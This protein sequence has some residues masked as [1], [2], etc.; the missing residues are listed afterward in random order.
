MPGVLIEPRFCVCLCASAKK[1]NAFEALL[2][3]G[4]LA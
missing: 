1:F 4:L 3:A 2:L